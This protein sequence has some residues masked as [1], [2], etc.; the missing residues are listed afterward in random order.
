MASLS[1]Y[2]IQRRMAA[3]FSESIQ[4]CDVL[5]IFLE[6]IAAHLRVWPS[7]IVAIVGSRK[8]RRNLELM[9]LQSGL[10]IKVVYKPGIIMV[11]T[12]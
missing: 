9:A 10:R 3:I 8:G 11:F 12:R 4:G 2:L 6:D 7:Q 1:A 5:E